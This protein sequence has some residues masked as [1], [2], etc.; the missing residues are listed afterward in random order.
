MRFDERTVRI[1]SGN[2]NVKSVTDTRII[3]TE[4]F[5]RSC[6]RK[7]AR[8]DSPVEIFRRAGLGPELIGHKRIERCIARWRRAET[9]RRRGRPPAGRVTL[10]LDRATM[11]GLSRLA[12]ERGQR[13]DECA[14]GIIAASVGAHGSQEEQ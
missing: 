14:A 6:M 3:Y 1:L 2:P 8:G 10:R 9:P 4:E 13:V 11:A 5:M 12:G 7:Y